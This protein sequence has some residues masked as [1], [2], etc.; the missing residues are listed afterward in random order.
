MVKN[1]EHAEH[2]EKVCRFLKK[3][4]DFSDWIITVTFYA[5]LHYVEHKLL[6]DHK[7]KN[8]KSHKKRKAVVQKNLPNI[9]GEYSHLLDMSQNARYRNYAKDREQVKV[10]EKHLETIKIYYTS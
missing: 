1:L 7:I 2:N 3:K 10:A 5:A 9:F 4:P 8:S 6:S